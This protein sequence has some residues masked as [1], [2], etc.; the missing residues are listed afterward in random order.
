MEVLKI[1]HRNVSSPF[2]FFFVVLSF[3][4]YCTTKP[5]RDLPIP[6]DAILL[7]VLTLLLCDTDPK[8][9][10]SNWK[11]PF[12]TRSDSCKVIKALSGL[13][14][15]MPV[16]VL[17]EILQSLIVTCPC[18]IYMPKGINIVSIISRIEGWRNVAYH[19]YNVWLTRMPRSD[20]ATISFVPFP[21]KKN[22]CLFQR[23]ATSWSSNIDTSGCTI[24]NETICDLQVKTNFF[25]TQ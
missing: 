23:S 19:E 2:F 22:I 16:N 1:W 12:D 25:A 3:K 14:T 6:S 18:S 7:F 4:F 24:V 5:E 13:I 17:L 21:I 15:L 20:S 10:S 11:V 8:R 9:G